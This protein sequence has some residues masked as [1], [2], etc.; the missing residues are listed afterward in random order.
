M[1]EQHDSAKGSPYDPSSNAGST[2]AAVKLKDSVCIA[3]LFFGVQAWFRLQRI[4]FPILSDSHA[5]NRLPGLIPNLDPPRG[6]VGGFEG[7]KRPDDCKAKKTYSDD[8]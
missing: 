6:N 8:F 1:C 3:L 7:I 2:G 4:V 5:R